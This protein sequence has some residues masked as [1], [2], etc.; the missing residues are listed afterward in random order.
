MD[1]FRSLKSVITSSRDLY[2]VGA[3]L[4][5]ISN[6]QKVTHD[7][8]FHKVVAGLCKGVRVHGAESMN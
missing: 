6:T 5:S 3:F 8:E 2:H 1:K 4:A 7:S